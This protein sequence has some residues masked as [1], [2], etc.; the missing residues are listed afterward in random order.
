MVLPLVREMLSPR[1]GREN[2]YAFAS[3][4]LHELCQSLESSQLQHPP[5]N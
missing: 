1:T 3:E 2:T 5:Q 4:L